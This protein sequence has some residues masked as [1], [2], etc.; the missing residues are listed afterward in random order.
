MQEAIDEILK[1]AEKIM[2]VK[3]ISFSLIHLKP[4]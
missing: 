2:K 3:Q 1:F 4:S